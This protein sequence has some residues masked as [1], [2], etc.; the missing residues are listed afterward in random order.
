MEIIM[1]LMI[2]SDIHGSE[3]Y[4]KLMLSAFEREGADSCSCSAIFCITVRETNCP[5]ITPRKR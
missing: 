3:Y 5:E 2:A 4:C 1:R